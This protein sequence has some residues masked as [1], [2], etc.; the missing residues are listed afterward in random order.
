MAGRKGQKSAVATSYG[1]PRE[2]KRGDP[3]KAATKS[4]DA[5]LIRQRFREAAAKRLAILTD[6]ADGKARVLRPFGKDADLISV[7]PDFIDKNRAMDTL[8][9]YGVPVQQEAD[10]TSNGETV[11]QQVW[12]FGNAKVQF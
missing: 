10:V 3:S 5:R 11:G 4:S 1:G 7:E 8:L 2:N 6:I 9:K 12:T